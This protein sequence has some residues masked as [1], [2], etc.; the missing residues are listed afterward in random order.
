MCPMTRFLQLGRFSGFHRRKIWTLTTI[1]RE[2]LLCLCAS[3]TCAVCSFHQFSISEQCCTTSMGSS[4]RTCFTNLACRCRNSCYARISCQDP[5]YLSPAFLYRH[6][7]IRDLN[8]W[9]KIGKVA[10]KPHF[11]EIPPHVWVVLGL[12]LIFVCAYDTDFCV[13]SHVVKRCKK[14]VP[15]TL[16]R[17][18]KD[19]VIPDHGLIPHIDCGYYKVGLDCDP[20]IFIAG[21]VFLVVGWWMGE[22]L[23][24]MASVVLQ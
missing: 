6:P 17:R 1:L 7:I 2:F 13:I 5:S 11:A 20:F 3:N 22:D 15:K 21:G 8:L 4:N 16:Q 23:K 24:G 19:A 18:T 10:H 14:R 9:S 12:L